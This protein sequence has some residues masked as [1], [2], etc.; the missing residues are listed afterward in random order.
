MTDHLKT[1]IRRYISLLQKEKGIEIRSNISD[2]INVRQTADQT[3][4]II[5]S[6][7]FHYISLRVAQNRSNRYKIS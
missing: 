5:Y 6:L 1:I 3:L 4:Q 2:L 7:Y